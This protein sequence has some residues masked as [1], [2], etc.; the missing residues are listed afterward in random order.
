MSIYNDLS[1]ELSKYNQYEYSS[2]KNVEFIGQGGF[3]KVYGAVHNDITVALKSFNYHDAAIK[4]IVREIK[5][6]HRG[7]IHP[8]IIKFYGITTKQDENDPNFIQYILVLEYAD[9]GA[10]R[11][12]LRK[13]FSS[14]TF[15]DKFNLAL[16]LAS[17][18]A[19]LH[20]EEILHCCWDDEI[21]KRS[22][23]QEVVQ[24][25]DGI[26]GIDGRPGGNASL[27]TP[28]ENGKVV[29]FKLSPSAKPGHLFINETECYLGKS[30]MIN[31]YAKGGLGGNGANGGRGIDGKDGSDGHR[32]NNSQATDGENGGDGGNGGNGS[33]GADGGNGGKITIITSKEYVY[34]FLF[35]GQYN[36]EGGSGG[37][38]GI[39]GEGGKGGKGGKR[40]GRNLWMELDGRPRYSSTGFD[41]L[42][43]KDGLPG[44]AHLTYGND[45]S[46]EAQNFSGIFEPGSKM[47]IHSM[48]FH[49]SGKMPTPINGIIILI[50]KSEIIVNSPNEQQ[51]VV[52][53]PVKI[54]EIFALRNPGDSNIYDLFWFVI[55]IGN[56]DLG[57]QSE[58]NRM[59]RMILY[60]DEELLT[61]FDVH[62]LRS[63][64]KRQMNSRVSLE[65]NKHERFLIILQIGKMDQP[66]SLKSIQ[67]RSF[68]INPE[69]SSKHDLIFDKNHAST[70]RE[71][72]NVDK[73]VLL[74]V[75][76]SNHVD[77]KNVLI[78]GTMRIDDF[79]IVLNLKFC[80]PTDGYIY[81]MSKHGDITITVSENERYLLLLLARTEDKSLVWKYNEINEK[82]NRI[83]KFNQI[84]RLE[85]DTFEFYKIEPMD[86]SEVYEP[87]SRVVIRKIKIKNTG[88]MSIP[89]NYDIRISIL[90]TTG[91][92]P[93]FNRTLVLPRA[94]KAHNR[95]TLD[96]KGK[97]SVGF[98]ID[99]QN[100]LAY[101]SSFQVEYIINLKAVMCGIER[102]IT[103]FTLPKKLVVRFPV[104]ICSKVGIRCI[105][106]KDL[107][108]IGLRLDNIS[109]IS[110]GSN[111]VSKR[112]LKVK[113]TLEKTNPPNS[114]AFKGGNNSENTSLI[115]DA[116]HLEA[117]KSLTMYCNLIATNGF[118]NN[119]LT[120]IKANLSATLQLETA[121]SLANILCGKTIVILNNQFEDLESVL[122]MTEGIKT[123]SQALDFIE[124]NHI[125]EAACNYG[126]K[127]F[128]IGPVICQNKLEKLIIPLIPKDEVFP[129]IITI[130]K[131]FKL[132]KEIIENGNEDNDLLRDKPRHEQIQF[133][134]VFGH[135]YDDDKII[136]C[137]TY[138]R[139]Q[140][141]LVYLNVKGDKIHRKEQIINRINI[142]G[143]LSCISFTKRL[144]KLRSLIL[145]S[146]KK[147]S[148]DKEILILLKELVE[149]D[150]SIEFVSLC[151]TCEILNK[152]SEGQFSKILIK[153]KFCE[154]AVNV[155]AKIR[156]LD[157]VHASWIFQVMAK[158]KV[159]L[160]FDE[161]PKP[162][163]NK[164]IDKLQRIIQSEYQKIFN[165]ITM[166]TRELKKYLP[167]LKH[168]TRKLKFAGNLMMK[169][170]HD[171]SELINAWN[172][173][174]NEEVY[175]TEKKYK[176]LMEN[177]E[178]LFFTI[179]KKTAT[180]LEF[181]NNQRLS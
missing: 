169:S 152:N 102:Q 132:K 142:V 23:I 107:T 147:E 82:H 54:S 58:C 17:A 35:V 44:T 97:D 26:I 61:S 73:L 3:R 8:N 163:K 109:K 151:G 181:I 159:L 46:K 157:N 47:I 91:I 52:R 59:I 118:N 18:V 124:P 14:L 140:R 170:F 95:A 21:E 110:L 177:H 57:E 53:Y 101:N 116:P 120:T 141:H 60:K 121:D 79:I 112:A 39:N 9:S 128:I 12:F 162:Y 179:S 154:F 19:Y 104:Q 160:E 130:E 165:T 136:F 33:S 86:S 171:L 145:T 125:H 92:T 117:N 24:R 96:F 77:S 149:V 138:D 48:E 88:G 29:E 111:S 100:Q 16:Q 108:T 41:G 143:F 78:E 20:S 148:L 164:R 150:L 134:P 25:R 34:L 98:E 176:E 158:L 90:D 89:D 93:V 62:L 49:N 106:N 50:Q 22:D 71:S 146:V 105:P 45:G 123:Y 38:P 36:V 135:S 127:F 99:K 32:T 174:S 55:N 85:L 66:Y 2:F 15:N 126:I 166:N 74:N 156:L 139:T 80:I 84:Y 40:G 83:D 1:R 6:Q 178:N 114:L 81:I 64:E 67:R 11:S 122:R 63:G 72:T 70:N 115:M 133:I 76:L 180:F 155:V 103:S 161:M 75:I 172:Y 65:E 173:F 31:F 69:K 119:P 42:D 94:I 68:Q 43:G 168:S 5:L 4:E 153:F 28:G 175:F 7:T 87:G 167:S 144:E 10:L 129:S 137:R 131:Y 113:F 27:P 13:N 56:S 30:G 37:V 51:L